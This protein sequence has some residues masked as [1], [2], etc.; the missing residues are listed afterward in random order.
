M[1]GVVD[2]S[3]T[4]GNAVGGASIIHPLALPN[5]EVSVAG[6]GLGEVLLIVVGQVAMRWEAQLH[7][8]IS[9][10]TARNAASLPTPPTPSAPRIAFTSSRLERGQVGEIFSVRCLSSSPTNSQFY[11]T[12][13][14]LIN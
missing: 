14:Q 8:S 11:L 10:S 9:H 5:G 3:R 6:S 7:L 2:C 1:R 13:S 12:A 4:G